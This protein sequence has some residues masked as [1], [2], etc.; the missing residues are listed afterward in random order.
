MCVCVQLGIYLGWNF[1]CKNQKGIY[2]PP[3]L[4]LQLLHFTMLS[5]INSAYRLCRVASTENSFIRYLDTCTLKRKGR[6]W[7]WTVI[8]PRNQYVSTF[9]II[10]RDV[11]VALL[12]LN[13][14]VKHSI[15]R[16]SYIYTD[17]ETHIFHTQDRP[18]ETE[19]VIFLS[20]VLSASGCV[21]IIL[22]LALAFLSPSWSP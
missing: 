1:T 14:F 7:E 16:A 13:K 5:A 19:N 10:L 18:T 15:L 22:R 2:Q 4:N 9:I 8:W 12:C 21:T 20:F 17:R 3:N 6:F 11:S